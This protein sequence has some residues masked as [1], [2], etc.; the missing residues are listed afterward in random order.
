MVAFFFSGHSD[1]GSGSCESFGAQPLDFSKLSTTDASSM[2]RA[3]LVKY[4]G[5]R[6]CLA[7]LLIVRQCKLKQR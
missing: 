1:F 3:F 2:H 7:M 4:P 5:L 6:L